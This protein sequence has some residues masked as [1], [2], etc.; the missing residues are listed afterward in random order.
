MP[1]NMTVTIEE[2][3]WKEMK[4][5]NEIRWSAVMKEAVKVKLNALSVLTQLANSTRLTEKEIE[6]FA[7][8]LGKKVNAR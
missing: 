2:P 1:H 7:L 8:R 5:H 4:K 6:E 3:L